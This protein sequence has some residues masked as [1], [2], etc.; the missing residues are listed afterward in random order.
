[1]TESRSTSLNSC[2][3]ICVE[4]CK[5]NELCAKRRQ[6]L[7]LELQNLT[8]AL[9]IKNNQLTALNSERFSHGGLSESNDKTWKKQTKTERTKQSNSVEQ[10]YNMSKR[11][12][13]HEITETELSDLASRVNSLQEENQRLTDTL[14][15][16]DKM[17][18]ELMT[19]YHSSL[20]EITELNGLF[21]L[22]YYVPF[23]IM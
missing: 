2:D 8:K 6:E 5:N 16:E 17:K 11:R 19:A 1:M 10:N 3:P 21:Q 4:A 23:V 18:Q 13:K 20:K 15:E 7:E 12:Q 9:T 14:K 22:L